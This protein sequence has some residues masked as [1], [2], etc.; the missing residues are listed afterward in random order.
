MTESHRPDGDFGD[1]VRQRRSELLLTQEALAERAGIAVRTVRTVEAGNGGRTRLHTRRLLQEALTDG[2]E[3]AAAVTVP[4]QVPLASPAF[5][6]RGPYLTALDQIRDANLP[7]GSAAVATVCGAPGTGKTA[8][9]I[10]WAHRNRASFPDG[11][12]YA[13]LDGFA[14]VAAMARPADVLRMFLLA[15]RIAEDR[16]PT[17]LG[18]RTALFREL[19]ADRRLLVV[20]DNAADVEQVRP[21]LPGAPAGMTVITSRPQLTGLV[22]VNGARPIVIRPCGPAEGLRVLATHAGAARI[23]A[24]TTAATRIVERCGGLPLAMAVIGARA[25]LQ[26][27]IPLTALADELAGD[28]LDML[29]GG[30][31]EVDLRSVFSWSYRALSPAAAGTFR[32]LGGFPLADV[33]VDAVAGGAGTASA[34]VRKALTELT[35]A[36][37]ITEL[38]P[39]RFGL[40]DLLHA[41]AR[42]LCVATDER[43]SAMGRIRRYYVETAEA[44]AA[45]IRPPADTGGTPPAPLP[46]GRDPLAWFAAEWRMLLPVLDDAARAGDDRTTLRLAAAVATFLHR[47]AAWQELADVG[48]R[49]LQCAKRLADPSAELAAQRTLGR[50]FT[51]LG[52]PDLARAHFAEALQLAADLQDEAAQAASLFDIAILF[53]SQGDYP[54][55]LRFVTRAKEL[56]ELL[57]DLGGKASA[58]NAIGWDLVQ[59]GTAQLAL[60]LCA[61]ALTLHRRAGNYHGQAATL[62][63]LG[64]AHHRLGEYTDAVDRLRDGLTIVGHTGDRHLEAVMLEHMGTA[65]A[66]N[67]DGTQAYEAWSRALAILDEIDQRGAEALRRRIASRAD[68]HR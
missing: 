55:S 37:L 32:L 26:P 57:G 41:Y 10:Q 52:K 5:I 8:L 11:Q 20:L 17:G 68:G 25:A 65:H 30:E 28:R 54:E 15:L 21:L 60:S 56:Y 40:H 34:E 19:V 3:A 16:I 33:T 61:E 23:A 2:Q 59:M 47:A 67:D 36:H 35:C 12:L 42:E 4:A 39:G 18:E 13:S 45:L 6:D 46:G 38:R 43:T 14:A 63:T 31:P 58:L 49:S 66:D 51:R 48:Q 22:A 44:A 53:E 9:A 50:A 27:E 7:P 64:V 62:D 29:D 1:W 24:D